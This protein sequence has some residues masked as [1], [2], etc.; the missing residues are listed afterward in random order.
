MQPGVGAE[1]VDVAADE[2]RVAP[3]E[4]ELALRGERRQRAGKQ[5]AVGALAEQIA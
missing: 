2:H 4:R 1:H 5:D 3:G